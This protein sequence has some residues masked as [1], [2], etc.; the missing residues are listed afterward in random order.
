MECLPGR[1]DA[2][3]FENQQSFLDE[4]AEKFMIKYP[5]VTEVTTLAAVAL[6][7]METYSITCLIVVNENKNRLAL[8]KFTVF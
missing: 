8:F 2:L 3:L 5:K 1:F 4:S 6:H 7:T